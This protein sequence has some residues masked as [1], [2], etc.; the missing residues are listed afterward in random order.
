VLRRRW[1][2]ERRTEGR[3]ARREEGA[4]HE[5]ATPSAGEL[6]EQAELQRLLASAV[7]AL[8]EP[9]R[10]TVLLR[11]FGGLSSFAIARR[12]GVSAGTVRS[13]LKRALAQLK[14]DLDRAHGGERRAWILAL[15]PVARVSSGALPAAL[16]ALSFLALGG[17]AWW[18]VRERL[19]G[20]SRAEELARASD[21]EAARSVVGQGSGPEV[22]TLAP[23]V[24]G[25]SPAGARR[26]VETP[27][28]E[29]LENEPA[30]GTLLGRVLD[31]RNGQP[32][33][34]VRLTVSERETSSDAAGRFSMEDLPIGESFIE[35]SSPFHPLQGHRVILASAAPEPMEL[36]LDPGLR[37][38]GRV[39][40]LSTRE[41]IPEAAILDAGKGREL[42]RSDIQGRFETLA[43]PWGGQ[44]DVGVAAAGYTGVRFYFRRAPDHGLEITLVRSTAVEGVVQDQNGKALSGARVWVDSNEVYFRDVRAGVEPGS[45][46]L[47]MPGEWRL[48]SDDHGTRTDEDGRFRM[49]ALP[50]QA[51][52]LWADV[53]PETAA[54]K[55]VVEARAPGESR[56]VELAL[57]V[58]ATPSGPTG[59]VAGVFRVNGEPREGTIHWENAGASGEVTTREGGSFRIERLAPGELRLSAKPRAFGGLWTD[60]A[61]SESKSFVVVADTTTELDLD[62]EF[63]TISI[64]GRV[65]LPTGEPAPGILVRARDTSSLSQQVRTR[66]GAS[67]AYELSV[68]AGRSYDICCFHGPEPPLRQGVRAGAQGIDFRLESFERLRLRAR[69]ARTG[70]PLEV[71]W[72]H[73]PAGRPEHWSRLRFGSEQAPD[74]E[75]FVEKEFATGDVE[76]AA[77]APY[78]GY[79]FRVSPVVTVRE[80]EATTVDIELVPGASLELLLSEPLPHGY[81]ELWPDEPPGS[82]VPIDCLKDWLRPILEFD[83]EGRALQLGLDPGTYSVVSSDPKIL[84]APERIRVGAETPE[85][86]VLTWRFE[87]R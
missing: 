41:P 50:W 13:R 74:T 47:A 61:A 35:S 66:T 10:S 9:Y 18:V 16:A 23:L 72:F 80:G 65:L 55:T 45:P 31:A 59:S 24:A 57:Q 38:S 44:V 48:T 70:R 27:A 19:T 60:A 11:Y 69:D 77:G 67:G 40:D 43:L 63:E 17:S 86:V 1:R 73:R 8:T 12:E 3:R 28:P 33:A 56:F 4:A 53:G 49:T 15:V 76:L 22:S 75:G 78:A 82:L 51:I 36:W 37:L 14:L 84:V 2:F 26:A 39:V 52:E 34:G 46:F 7:L 6:A 5:E 32:V 54:V 58:R 87:D 20:G 29:A 83:P 62:F 68:L 30:T 85:P 71:L 42:T 64:R 25:A 79:P 21:G 81:L